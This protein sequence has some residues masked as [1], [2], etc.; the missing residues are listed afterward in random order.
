MIHVCSLDRLAETV[1]A[2]GARRVVTLIDIGTP[3]T[4]PGGIAVEHHLHL[5]IHDICLPLDGYIHPQEE[6]VARLIDFVRDW[7]QTAPLVVHCYAGISRS[8]A[9]A[10]TAACTIHPDRDELAIARALRTASPT[11]CPNRLIVSLADRLLGRDGRMIAAVEAIAP[12]EPC[13]SAVPFCLTL[14]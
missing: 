2:T 6:H 8:T 1:A 14:E 5:E 10:F 11:A 4:R 9:A 3:V 7:D 13:L 12:H